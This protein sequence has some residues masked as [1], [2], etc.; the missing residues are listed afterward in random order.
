ML[1]V[2]VRDACR[3]KLLCTAVYTAVAGC[4]PPHR[5]SRPIRTR[6]FP[7]TSLAPPL[8]I[9]PSS[10]LPICAPPHSSPLHGPPLRFSPC[11]LFH[12]LH[13]SSIRSATLS[14]LFLSAPRIPYTLLLNSTLLL[15]SPDPHSAS[16]TTPP[17]S[18]R[19]FPPTVA[20]SLLP[21]VSASHLQLPHLCFQPAP[22]WLP[23]LSLRRRVSVS[24]TPLPTRRT[25]WGCCSRRQSC[26]SAALPSTFSR[27]FNSNGESASAQ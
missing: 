27:C 9:Y 1:P 17:P 25:S 23:R 5:A 12:P 7:P 19:A 26:H 3:S 8:L 2:C 4:T 6:R 11:L 13:S 24:T 21:N 22:G 14:S 20:P 10:Y 18:V 15:P 16:H